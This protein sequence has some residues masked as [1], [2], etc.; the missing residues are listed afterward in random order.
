[1]KLKI[2]ISALLMMLFSV[3]ANADEA[4]NLQLPVDIVINDVFLTTEI[5][6]YMENN[7]TYIPLRTAFTAMGAAV[8]WDDANKCAYITDGGN[9]I[10]LTVYG[11]VVNNGGVES[12][13]STGYTIRNDR[14]Y[15]PS[16]LVTGLLGGSVEWN[17]KFATV[18][19][20]KAGVT[21]PENLVNKSYGANEIYWLS[22]IIEAESGG[23]PFAGKIGVGNVVMNRVK[24]K[25]FPNTIFEVIFDCRYGV[26]FQPISNGSIFNNPSRDSVI[27]A[28]HALRG[29][30]LVGES[31]Y[32]L[33]PRIAKSK[34]IIN[35]RKYY[36]TIANHDFYL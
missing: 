3:T 29:S 24:S 8:E 7:V 22:R 17:E 13:F 16:R 26:Q 15:V 1:M 32:F 20:N 11:G 14:A 19:I 34:W 6:P 4:E 12:P 28:K 10:T 25:E 21:V 5:P 33:N 23:E 36:K 30:C 9:V 27:A 18:I 2:L 35:N 31:M